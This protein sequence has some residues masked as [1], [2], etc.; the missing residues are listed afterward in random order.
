LN[1]FY[2]KRIATRPPQNVAHEAF[3]IF[4]MQMAAGPRHRA[5][6]EQHVCAIRFA[7]QLTA[8]TMRVHGI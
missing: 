5:R 6:P 8:E 7:P 4:T 1:R 2:L 3:V